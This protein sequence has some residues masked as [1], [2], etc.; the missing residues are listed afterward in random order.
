MRMHPD[1][2]PVPQADGL[3]GQ[4]RPWFDRRPSGRLR[5]TSPAAREELEAFAAAVRDA[6]GG[7]AVDVERWPYRHAGTTWWAFDAE[8]SGG[9]VSLTFVET[10][11]TQLPT[12]SP[13][14]GT[15]EVAD[16]VDAHYLLEFLARELSPSL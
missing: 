7:P 10:G 8:G 5:I 6:L 14:N 12:A 4:T 13:A 2:S 9:S 15:G 3:V 11:K 1:T 16:A